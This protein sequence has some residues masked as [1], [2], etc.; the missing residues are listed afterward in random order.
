MT[1]VL[2]VDQ[3]NPSP[4]VVEQ[5]AKTLRSQGVL[6]LPTDSVYG[7]ACAA[8]PAN[9][10]HGRIFDIKH[11][12]RAQT[13]PWFVADASDLDRYGAQVPAWAHRLA[14]R[15]WPGALTLVV[16]AS[17]EVPPEY[18]HAFDGGPST[19]AL[20]VPGSELVRAL[21]R[22]VGPL[23]QTSANTHGQASATSGESVEPAIAREADLVLDGGAAPLAVASTIVEATGKAPRILREGALS[24]HEVLLA[25]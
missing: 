11:R 19:I 5:A 17:S 3:N 23:A 9:P 24:G 14:A 16:R 2:Y 22:E 4:E 13:L 21:V 15:F 20:R 1:P 12:D 7:L 18:A 8:T 10:A 25:V 6:V